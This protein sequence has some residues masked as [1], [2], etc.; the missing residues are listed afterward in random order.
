MVLDT[1]IEFAE[2]AAEFLSNFGEELVYKPSSPDP[3]R[4]MGIRNLEWK[5]PVVPKCREFSNV[6]I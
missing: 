1:R 6:E 4:D 3:M 5:S 2:L